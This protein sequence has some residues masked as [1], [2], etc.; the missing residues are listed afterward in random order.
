MIPSRTSSAFVCLRCELQYARGRVP[1]T[2]ARRLPHSKFSTSTIHRDALDELDKATQAPSEENHTAE[3]SEH[4]IIRIRRPKGQAEVR[5]RIARLGGLKRLGSDAEILVIRGLEQGSHRSEAAPKPSEPEETPSETDAPSILASLAAE[6]AVGQ[7]EVNQQLDSLRPKSHCAPDEPNYISEAEFR[8]LTKVLGEGF[9]VKQLERYLKARKRMASEEKQ[10]AQE[11]NENPEAGLLSDHHCTKP[12]PRDVQGRSLWTP[13]TSPL[14]ERLPIHAGKRKNMNHHTKKRLLV[15]R[16]LR[17][18]WRTAPLEEVESPGE[19][20]LTLKPWQIQLLNLSTTAGGSESGTTSTALDR[21]ANLRKARI[22][23]PKSFSGIRI[24]APKSN[25]EYAADDIAGLLKNSAKGSFSLRDWLTGKFLSS[26]DG[27][28]EVRTMFPKGSLETIERLSGVTIERPINST[29]NLN[30]RGLDKNAVE[31]AKRSIIRLLPLRDSRT[32]HL[33]ADL[34]EDGTFL[35]PVAF[36]NHLEYQHR[37]VDLGRWT[38]RINRQEKDGKHDIQKASTS[39]ADIQ[40][41]QKKVLE[42][43]GRNFEPPPLFHRPPGPQWERYPTNSL[44]ASFGHILFPIGD[45]LPN[46]RYSAP[47]FSSSIPGT[48]KFLASIEN[49]HY[50]D[51]LEYNFVPSP[52]SRDNKPQRPLLRYPTLSLKIRAQPVP[53]LRG[54]TLSF[55]RHDYDILLPGHA[56]DLRLS[57]RRDIRL[58]LPFED[59]NIRAFY[60]A[61]SENIQSKGKLTAPA[62]LRLGIP[63]WTLGATWLEGEE[64]DEV[65]EVTYLFTG[66]SHRQHL[67]GLWDGYRVAYHTSQEG[68]LGLNSGRLSLYWDHEASRRSGGDGLMGFVEKAFKMADV[69]TGLAGDTMPL[70]QSVPARPRMQKENKVGV[71]EGLQEAKETAQKGSDKREL[72]GNDLADSADSAA[73]LPPSV[74]DAIP[75]EG[76][77]DPVGTVEGLDTGPHVTAEDV[78]E[79]LP[80]EGSQTG[81]ADSDESTSDKS[82]SVQSSST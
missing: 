8:K 67:N 55:R 12:L 9:T 19:I 37:E 16:I 56:T 2:H 15:D 64:R 68:T 32:W 60:D 75:A 30:I 39:D 29:L 73:E 70:R 10:G 65:E 21:I 79:D 20:E 45:T 25:A 81:K 48:S 50:T 36:R 52:H 5:E 72:G 41:L 43:I 71:Q 27:L 47:V 69:L 40:V 46:P 24:T 31:E 76:V 49:P 14:S 82:A 23:I 54:V 78:V 4:P 80:E 13:G 57:V 22:E 35:A 6:G 53:S 1:R 62:T 7:D 44:S 18:L 3:F 77:E 28:T 26:R 51:N 11:L 38:A 33:E 63:T 58:L 42:A 17:S 59:Q 66:I 61:V 34:R 74:E